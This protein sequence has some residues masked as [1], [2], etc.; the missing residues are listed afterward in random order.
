MADA[1]EKGISYEIRLK[2]HQGLSVKSAPAP[3]APSPENLIS[4]NPKSSMSRNSS[5][6]STMGGDEAAPARGQGPLCL[7]GTS[8]ASFMKTHNTD[9]NTC[10]FSCTRPHPA[11]AGGSH[12]FQEL[13][14][15]KNPPWAWGEAGGSQSLLGQP[16]RVP[17]DVPH[18]SQSCCPLPRAQN[19]Q[20][21]PLTTAGTGGLRG[22]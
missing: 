17:P 11:G 12:P 1:G 14:E 16:P 9:R 19:Q 10:S 18:P 8:T 15:G 3:G 13:E 7:T 21:E 4:P 5:P 20:Q 6:D 2:D 22:C